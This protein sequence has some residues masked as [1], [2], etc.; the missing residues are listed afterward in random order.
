MEIKENMR[1]DDINEINKIMNDLFKSVS[2][3]DTTTSDTTASPSNEY[4]PS[5][6]S[7]NNNKK[8]VWSTGFRVKTF[9]AGREYIIVHKHIH[10][11]N[12]NDKRSTSFDFFRARNFDIAKRWV[13]NDIKL[14][15]K[16]LVSLVDANQEG[17]SLD[18]LKFNCQGNDLFGLAKYHLSGGTCTDVYYFADVKNINEEAL[19]KEEEKSSN[20]DVLQIYNLF[21]G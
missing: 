2:S 4:K 21:K 3:S 19:Q 14:I 1:I 12:G 17:I 6:S 5:T 18:D 10:I 13:M 9:T 15:V 16:Q 8:P 7:F 20:M 11:S